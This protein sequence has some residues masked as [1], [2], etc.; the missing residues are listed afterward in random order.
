MQRKDKDSHSTQARVNGK[1]D[2]E[3]E[4]YTIL[5]LGKLELGISH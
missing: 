4:K 1:Q 5:P 3:K 2:G